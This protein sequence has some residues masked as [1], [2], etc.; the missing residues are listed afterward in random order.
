MVPVPAQEPGSAVNGL[1][2]VAAWTMLGDIRLGDIVMRDRSASAAPLRA[3]R[4][5]L[6]GPF[7]RVFMLFMPP[8]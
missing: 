5:S 6:L 2:V 8:V 3:Q 1:S 4:R 7:A